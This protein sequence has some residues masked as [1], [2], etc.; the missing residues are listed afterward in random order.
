MRRR[1]NT[2]VCVGGHFEGQR[3]GTSFPLSKSC[4]NAR[5]QR[6]HCQECLRTHANA[7]WAAGDN[8]FLAKNA[9]AAFC[10]GLY[11]I[12][13][14]PGVIP[15]PPDCRSGRER[16]PPAPRTTTPL[17]PTHGKKPCVGRK[18]PVLGRRQQFPFGS[19]A[20]PLLLFYETTIGVCVCVCVCV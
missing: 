6:S 12:N 20:F 5:E 18:R 17:R 4:F 8:H 15:P 10:I 7:L 9:P 3:V 16:L 2:Y 1:G 14:F 11:S 13:I 19:P